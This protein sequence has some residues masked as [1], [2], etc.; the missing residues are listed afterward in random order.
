MGHIK[1]MKYIYKLSHLVVN[2]SQKPE[3]FGRVVAE[4]MASG[5]AVVAYDHGGVSEQISILDEN[6]RIP[7]NNIQKMAQSIDNIL[8]MSQESINLIG[9]ISSSFIKKNFTKQNMISSTLNLYKNLL[10]LREYE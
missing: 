9:K 5:R 1:D 10:N 3:G 4:A 7:I 6:S 2:A 8:N